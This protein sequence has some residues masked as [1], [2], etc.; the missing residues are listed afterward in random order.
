MKRIINKQIWKTFLVLAIFG[1]LA[2]CQPA[3]E[4]KKITIVSTNDFHGQIESNVHKDLGHRQYGGFNWLLGYYKAVRAENP[5]GTLILDGGDLW[6]GTILSNLTMGKAVIDLYN[7]AGYDAV[8]IG[9]HEFDFGPGES[10]TQDL[11]F[12]LKQRLQEA[13][14]PMLG[15][16]VIKIEDR[17][18]LEMPNFK[19]YV[20][21]EKKGIKIGIIGLASPSTAVTTAPKHILDLEFTDGASAVH[22]Y[23]KLLREQGASAIILLTHQGATWNTET[24]QWEGEVVDLV[25]QVAG[26]VDLVIG[27]HTHTVISERING[28]P[29]MSAGYYGRSFTRSDMTFVSRG[30]QNK[31]V[32]TDM[33][34]P[35]FFV[36]Q[37]TSDAPPTYHGQTI[38]PDTSFDAKFA[39]YSEQIKKLKEKP[40]GLAAKDFSR[41]GTDNQVG[42]LVTDALMEVASNADM[43]VTNRGSLRSNLPAGQITFGHIYKVMPFDNE[44]VTVQLRGEQLVRAFEHG[45]K[46]GNWP[47]EVSGIKI[48]V[49]KDAPEGQRVQKV[50][51][52]DGSEMLSDKVYTVV[53]NDFLYDRGDG[54]NAISEGPKTNLSIK[55]RDL[56][57]DYV[58]DHSPITPDNQPRI[59]IE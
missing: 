3:E 44:A 47:L 6:Q 8:A 19:P 11:R 39:E 4:I 55:V 31:L 12:V 30:Q 35:T 10:G 21:L 51:L 20:M 14:F 57:S 33:E 1:C 58:R 42:H 28:V 36:H 25:K 37:S 16:N 2:S 40:F 41:D 46:D 43:A 29:V 34:G 53:T 27:G 17:Q 24:K 9:N 50:L 54:F 26:E 13:K 52:K 59:V 7:Q 23:S 48:F 5:E 15:A 56:L 18:P 49:K 22:K 45:F 32:K 38:I